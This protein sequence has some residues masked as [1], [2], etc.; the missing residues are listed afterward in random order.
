MRGSIFGLLL[1]LIYIYNIINSS[2]V[3]VLLADD[4]TV[5]VK[6]NSIDREIEIL[7]TEFAKVALWFDSK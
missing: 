2:N 7:N 4:T 3:L 5:Y 1:F 6:N